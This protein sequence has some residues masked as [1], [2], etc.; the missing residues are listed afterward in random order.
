MIRATEVKLQKRNLGTVKVQYTSPG[1]T[2]TEREHGYRDVKAHSLWGDFAVTSLVVGKG[3]TV[4]HIPS[5][6][7]TCPR[8]FK[9]IREAD[10]YL[11]LF[12]K[13]IDG[14]PTK[15]SGPAYLLT[16]DMTEE[17]REAFNL[18]V[19]VLREIWQRWTGEAAENE[20]R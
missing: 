13:H 8:D 15:L 3:Y 6:L 2:L 17:E 4:T 18:A 1:R 7:K 12:P 16:V 11:K 9:T 10:A 19:G 20:G 5:G 14:L